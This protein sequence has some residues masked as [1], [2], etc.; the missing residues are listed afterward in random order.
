MKGKLP[1]MAI[2]AVPTALAA[3][4]LVGLVSALTGDG[5]RDAISWATLAMPLAA[6]AWAMR[7]RR[8]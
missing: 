7:A 8:S 5:L 2:F 1:M 4:S 3:L 6:V